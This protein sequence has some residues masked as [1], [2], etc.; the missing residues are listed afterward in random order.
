MENHPIT[1]NPIDLLYR[2]VSAYPGEERQK[3]KQ[4]LEEYLSNV[5]MQEGCSLSEQLPGIVSEYLWESVQ[6]YTLSMNCPVAVDTALADYRKL[7]S[8]ASPC[9]LLTEKAVEVMEKVK[10]IESLPGYYKSRDELEQMIRALAGAEQEAVFVRLRHRLEDML[11]EVIVPAV[12]EQ[13]K[14]PPANL[15]AQYD[16]WQ[17]LK[18]CQRYTVD[19]FA[20]YFLA[21]EKEAFRV[22]L[23]CCLTHVD[24]VEQTYRAARIIARLTP[25][26]ADG[27]RASLFAILFLWTEE[28]ALRHIGTKKADADTVLMQELY[29]LLLDSL[30]RGDYRFWENP[31]FREL[32][33][34]LSFHSQNAKEDEQHE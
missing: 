13:E 22:L 16:L 7:N 18:L 14:K 2:I 32:S 19:R 30:K 3:A 11:L 17:D 29:L 34:T 5:P 27:E 12:L 26:L 31:R 8:T 23:P 25:Q 1:E 4:S 10:K 20:L 6:R 28:R 15:E 33:N 21:I 24:G 9:V